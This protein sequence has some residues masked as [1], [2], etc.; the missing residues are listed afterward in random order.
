MHLEK[1]LREKP[2]TMSISACDMVVSAH[3]LPNED[4]RELAMEQFPIGSS[5]VVRQVLAATVPL[6]AAIDPDEDFDEDDEE[7]EEEPEIRTIYS[8][9]RDRELVAIGINLIH[10]EKEIRR[11]H[12]KTEGEWGHTNNGCD[13]DCNQRW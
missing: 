1:A 6:S 3:L 12:C 9:E 5:E 11:E 2:Q 13:D 4:E 8:T 7:N 10:E